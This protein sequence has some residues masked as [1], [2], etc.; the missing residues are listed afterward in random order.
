MYNGSAIKIAQHKLKT[1]L[2]KHI[3]VRHDHLVYH[4]RKQSI[5]L[6]HIASNHNE[7]YILT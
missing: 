4:V 7:G 3:D 5:R 2:R 1:E 6:S